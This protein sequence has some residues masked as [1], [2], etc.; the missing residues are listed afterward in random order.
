MKQCICHDSERKRKQNLRSKNSPTQ[1]KKII[2]SD[3]AE[4]KIVTLPRT[5]ALNEK[6]KRVNENKCSFAATS[7]REKSQ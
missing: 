1:K 5:N 6:K 4:E 3:I 7:E 2:N